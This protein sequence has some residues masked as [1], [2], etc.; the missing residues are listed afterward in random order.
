LMEPKVAAVL[1]EAA[2][3][4]G[5]TYMLITPRA[6]TADDWQRNQRPPRPTIVA[7]RELDAP[8]WPQNRG[9]SLAPGQLLL[10]APLSPATCHALR[11][12]G[13]LLAG[14]SKALAGLNALDTPPTPLSL[15]VLDKIRVAVNAS[16]DEAKPISGIA[17]DADDAQDDDDEAAADGDDDLDY[18]QRAEEAAAADMAAL[19]LEAYGEGADNDGGDVPKDPVAEARDAEARLQRAVSAIAGAAAR[20]KAMARGVAPPPPPLADQVAAYRAALLPPDEA[21]KPLGEL[22]KGFRADLAQRQ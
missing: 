2:A 4:E 7:G 9:E 14:A 3:R 19:E 21:S 10:R 12:T 16:P 8:G 20:S 5:F 15:N 17:S 1:S 22:L 13:V 18:V 11:T 6:A